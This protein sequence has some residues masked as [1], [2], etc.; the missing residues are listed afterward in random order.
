L[1]WHELQGKY[2]PGLVFLDRASMMSFMDNSISPSEQP[3]NPD[4]SEIAKAFSSLGA[5]KGGKARA[6]SLS[7]ERRTEIARIAVETRWAK[8]GIQPALR[9]T[10]T[11]IMKIGTLELECAVLDNGERVLSQRGFMGA[12]GI[13]HGGA[14]SAVRVDDIGGAVYPL[15][16]AYKNLR[17]FIDNDLLAVL[18]EPRKYLH[19][20]GGGLAFGV[21]AELIPRIC[22]VWLKARDVGVLGKGQGAVATK[23]DILMRGLAHVGIVALVDEATGYQDDRAR[24]AL[25][26]I[27]EAFVAKELRRWVKTFPTEYYKELFRLRGLV[28]PPN[29]NPPQYIGRLTNDLIYSRLAP[30]VLEELKRKNPVNETGYR[31]HKHHQW[32]TE[33]TGHPKLLQHLAAVVSLM[34]AADEWN[35]FKKMLDRS[36]P[37]QTPMP[38]FDTLPEP[39]EAPS[40]A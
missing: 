35:Q 3:A 36:L 2:L 18:N 8:K 17:P 25:A 16:V 5:S 40:I 7:P 23:A 26:K 11:G 31:Q 37:K 4:S 13:K 20:Q 22:E 19:G 1:L 24:D 32:L 28:Y 10:H 27:L 15:Y 9:A 39:A 29:K 34:R 33:D 14:M 30:G 21:K 6:Q 38:L 12:L